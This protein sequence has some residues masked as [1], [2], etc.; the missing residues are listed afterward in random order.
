MGNPFKGSTLSHKPMVRNVVTSQYGAICMQERRKE[1][2]ASYYDA[3]ITLTSAPFSCTN[4][5]TVSVCTY[6]STS[7]SFLRL[8]PSFLF[9]STRSSK[10]Q[11]ALHRH[12]STPH[13]HN[14]MFYDVS[15]TGNILLILLSG[16]NDITRAEYTTNPAPGVMDGK[17]S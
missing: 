13:S 5:P 12:L 6:R 15:S 3:N 1:S 9:L 10:E 16:R 14:K 8:F 7:L 2:S 11:R 4:A 17:G